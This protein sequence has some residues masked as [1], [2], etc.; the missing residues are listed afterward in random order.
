VCTLAVFTRVFPAHP[1]VVAA[2]RDELLARLATPPGLLREAP[3]RAVGGRDAVARGTW[4]GVNEDGLIA[5]VLNR[6]VPA[7]PDPA[8]RSR[9]LLCADLLAYG[10]AVEA[11][12]RLA[13]EPAGRYNPFNLL[14]ADRADAF[15]ASQPPGER[16]RVTRL[17]AGLHLLTNLDLNDPTCPRIAA[18]HRHFVTV[19]DAFAHTGDVPALVERLQAVLGDHATP[20]DPRGPGSLC[21]HAES[22]GTRSSSVIVV[23]A[24]GRMLYF[25]ADG[26]PCHTPLEPIALPF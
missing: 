2:N 14:V 12:A 6:R 17:E 1:L 26:P 7:P 19:G 10:A 13:T 9:G 24:V 20:L 5:G 4:L 21:V 8:C 25:H 15:V 18:S 23:P 16:P 11:A 3:P 22:Y